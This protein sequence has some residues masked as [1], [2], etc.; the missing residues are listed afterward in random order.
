MDKKKPPAE[1][2]SD[3]SFEELNVVEMDESKRTCCWCVPLLPSM[4][5]YVLVGITEM[6][7]A[8]IWNHTLGYVFASLLIA[9]SATVILIYFLRNDWLK[10]CSYLFYLFG[11][12]ICVII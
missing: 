8:S 9:F 4:V 2:V 7:L 5:L 10:V 3:A 11:I 1:L 12:M 6:V